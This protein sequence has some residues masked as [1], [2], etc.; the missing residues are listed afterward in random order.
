[1]KNL[2]MAIMT[3]GVLG[4]ALPALAQ[5]EADE[6]AAHHPAPTGQVDTP[7]NSAGDGFE[8]MRSLI[9][10][11]QAA[12]DPA[13]RSELLTEHLQLMREQVRAMRVPPKPAGDSGHDHSAA[14][15]AK[16][17]ESAGAGKKGGMMDKC[18]MMD[19]GGMMKK[20]GGMMGM[21]KR[22]EQR[23]DAIE[24]MLEQLVEREAL[25]P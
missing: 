3:A 2:T 6:H 21:H 11:A 20:K 9:A 13:V 18:S 17:A 1:M 4:L 25:E 19:K 15:A 16:T 24:Q 23:L 12:Q 8:R 22:V 14:A 7:V 5:E 10:Q